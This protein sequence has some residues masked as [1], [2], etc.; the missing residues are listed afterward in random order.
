MA[1]REDWIINGFQFGSEK[2]ANQA[3]SEEL[4]IQSWRRRW[5]IV[6]RR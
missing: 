2:D 3:K 5:T 1:G 6:I 4:K